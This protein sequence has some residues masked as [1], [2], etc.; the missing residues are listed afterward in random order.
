ME[1]QTYL[2]YEFFGAV[3][4][5]V[6]DDMQAIADCHS[7]A[8]AL[9]LPVRAKDDATYYIGGRAVTACIQTDTHWGSAKF[10]IDDRKV[11]DR[12]QNCFVVAPDMPRF[13]LQLQTLSRDQTCLEMPQSGNWYV[14]VENTNRRV[15]IRKGLNQ[16]EGF[17]ATDRFLV[18]STGKILNPINWDYDTI[19]EAWAQSTDD[20][21]ITIS[22][23]IFTT[24]ANEEP[25]FYN[26][27][28]RNIRIH[29]SH[30][31]LENLTHYVENE[32]DH[33][34]PYDG[35][36]SIKYASFV[37]IRDCL[38]TA[39]KIYKTPSQIPG[40]L[41]DM[42]SY[43]LLVNDSVEIHFRNIRQTTDIL[44]KAY[45]GI[46]CSNFCKELHLE[47]CVIS[48]FDAHCGVTNGSIRN[49]TLG[50]QGINLIGFGRFLVENTT[51]TA[52]RFLNFRSDYGSFFRGQL[53]VRN[54]RWIPVPGKVRPM[55]IFLAQN[56]GDHDF[57]YPCM[58]P[59]TV[60][61]KN[62]VIDDAHLTQEDIRY[63]IFRD[64]DPDYRPGKPYP[65]ATPAV[66][67][68][69]IQTTSGRQVALCDDLEKFP[70]WRN[71][72]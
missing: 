46:F 2:T 27:Y 68:A 1:Q 26:Y 36:I 60:T 17:P 62:F 54:C 42:G 63:V 34:A 38:L 32:G 72:Q 66:L 39:H 24:I 61:L 29:R 58:L 40:K 56:T 70:N 22:G 10:I 21:P 69:G 67:T 25:S 7:R 28:E 18:D 41:V 55:Y 19:T 35:F 37:T 30:V 16:D 52:T 20:R 44:D 64:Y 23:G 48:R 9:G 15:Y 12:Q 51:V 71:Y 47:N 43:D 14:S 8:N 4:D 31:T 59:E 11:E 33:G 53:T 50:H 13:P 45:W 6:H 5:G 49:C 3:G 57:G 65:F